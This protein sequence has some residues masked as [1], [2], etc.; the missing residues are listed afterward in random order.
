MNITYGKNYTTEELEVLNKKHFEFLDEIG[1]VYYDGFWVAGKPKFFLTD[2]TLNNSEKP[3]SVEPFKERFVF[4]E[5]SGILS[6]GDNPFPCSDSRLTIVR[7]GEEKNQCGYIETASELNHTSIVS[8]LSVKIG[9]N[10]LFGP[11]VVIMDTDRHP[12]DRRLSDIPEN[13]K[14]APV[15]IEDDFWIGCGATIMKGV[16]IGHHSVV[17]A[18][19][20]VVKMFRHILLLQETRRKLLKLLEYIN[21]VASKPL[22]SSMRHLMQLF[23]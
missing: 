18:K 22:R 15:N 16:T 7:W 17:A 3:F 21:V 10:V 23:E 20:L 1:A 9:E 5:G 11:A 2:L 8:A 19:S 14:M 4:K 6:T 13:R 12:A